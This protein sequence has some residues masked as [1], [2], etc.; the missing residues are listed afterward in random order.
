MT[1]TVGIDTAIEVTARRASQLALACAAH[2]TVAMV[3]DPV[4]DH[5]CD[6]R[7]TLRAAPRSAG[8]RLDGTLKPASRGMCGHRARC[9]SRSVEPHRAW[10]PRVARV[11]SPVSVLATSIGLLIGLVSG[12]SRI[13]EQS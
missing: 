11:A 13:A 4:D 2:P 5:H 12:Y 1:D 6:T 9:R 8:R 10:R 7:R 3:S